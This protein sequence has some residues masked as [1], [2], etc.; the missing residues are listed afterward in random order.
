MTGTQPRSRISSS[1][2]EDSTN[3]EVDWSISLEMT[4]IRVGVTVDVDVG[5]LHSDSA[6]ERFRGIRMGEVDGA[7]LVGH[8]QIDS[9]RSRAGEHVC[10]LRHAEQ[11]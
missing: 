7:D 1:T 6:K 4:S 11:N 9:G 8:A 10:Q 2:S 5:G 3:S